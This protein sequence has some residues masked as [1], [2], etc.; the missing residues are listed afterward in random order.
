MSSENGFPTESCLI[1]GKME[2]IW[3]ERMS[4]RSQYQSNGTTSLALMATYR[5]LAIA[6]VIDY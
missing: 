2:F 1:G 4:A 6:P 5:Q 3:I